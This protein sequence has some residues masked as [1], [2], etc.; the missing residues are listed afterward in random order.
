VL[1]G[2]KTYDFILKTHLFLY[3][4]NIVGNKNNMDILNAF[5]MIP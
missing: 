5:P 1:L 3:M 4:S 2:V